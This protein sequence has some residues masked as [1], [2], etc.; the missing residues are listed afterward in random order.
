MYGS[1]FPKTAIVSIK[2]QHKF[3]KAYANPSALNEFLDSRADK[4]GVT[5]Q[6]W[7]DCTLGRR[8]VCFFRGSRLNSHHPH[9]CSQPSVVLVPGEPMF[10]SGFCRHY[11]HIVHRYA[12][13]QNTYKHKM[14]INKIFKKCYL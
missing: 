12:F 8:I 13:R 6:D 11:R 2:F 3:W 14:K 1:H 9:G 10:S 4:W 7:R 5:F